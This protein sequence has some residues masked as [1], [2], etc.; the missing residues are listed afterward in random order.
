MHWSFIYVQVL[1]IKMKVKFITCSRFLLTVTRIVR[2]EVRLDCE[3]VNIRDI[4]I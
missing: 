4:R 2:D 1:G 3:Y